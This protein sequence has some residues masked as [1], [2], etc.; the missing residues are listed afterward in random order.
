[1]EIDSV[2]AGALELQPADG[3]VAHARAIAAVGHVSVDSGR[4]FNRMIR[5]IRAVRE[6][7]VEPACRRIPEP[8]SAGHRADRAGV[9]ETPSGSAVAEDVVRLLGQS[10]NVSR[11]AVG[12]PSGNDVT[13]VDDR[14][15][16]AS[17]RC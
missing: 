16:T 14:L 5:W 1:M 12:L 8:R 4:G 6:P 10:G 11:S 2:A 15:G 3:D 13:T 7:E 9:G 17:V